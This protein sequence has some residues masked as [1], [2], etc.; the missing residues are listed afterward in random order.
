MYSLY[1][2]LHLYTTTWKYVFCISYIQK[3]VCNVPLWLVLCAVCIDFVCVLFL[4]RVNMGLLQET[5]FC[6]GLLVYNQTLV[7]LKKTNRLRRQMFSHWHVYELPISNSHYVMPVAWA[8]YLLVIE[9]VLWSR[10]DFFVMIFRSYW[11]QRKSVYFTVPLRF[12][13]ETSFTPGF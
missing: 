2:L 8:Q 11:S 1:L 6:L 9:Y 12:W 7:L 5:K 13:N 4:E 10:H 3:R